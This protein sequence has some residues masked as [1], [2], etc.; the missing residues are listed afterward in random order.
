MFPYISSTIIIGIY[1]FLNW[2][3]PDRLKVFSWLMRLL[4]AVLLGLAVASVDFFI[5]LVF[6]EYDN[7]SKYWEWQFPQYALD[8]MALTLALYTATRVSSLNTRDTGLLILAAVFA[9]WL[10]S[11][12]LFPSLMELF[13]YGSFNFNAFTEEFT[14]LERLTNYYFLRGVVI[15]SA[16]SV[17]FILVLLGRSQA[18]SSKTLSRPGQEITVRF[19]SSSNEPAR[20]LMGMAAAGRLPMI[21][22]LRQEQEHPCQASP[23]ELDVDREKLIE[24]ADKRDEDANSNRFWYFGSAVLALISIGAEAPG[25]V[26]ISILVAGV[27]VFRQGRRDRATLV[28]AYQPK[29]FEPPNPPDGDDSIQNLITYAGYDPFSQFGV[30]FGS[31]VLMVD[32][33]RAK[34]DELVEKALVDP[35]IGEIERT[36]AETMTQ[37]GQ[38]V[39]APR[40]LYFVQGANIPEDIKCE[41]AVRPPRNLHGD[42]FYENKFAKHAADPDSPVRRYLWI[43]KSIWGREISISYFVRLFRHGSD[44]N[45]EING[46][47]MPPVAA[48]YRWVDQFAPQ[49]FWGV[50]FDLFVSLIVGAW[51]LVWTPLYVVG[52]AQDAI[53]EGFGSKDR[54]RRNLARSVERTANYDFGAPVS[55]RKQV[56]DFGP[57]QYFQKMDRRAAEAAFAGRVTRCFIDYLDTCNIDTSELR[58]QRTTL[59]NQGIV[60]QGGDVKSENLAVGAGAKVKALGARARNSMGGGS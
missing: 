31:W 14:N 48:Q 44:L 41:G 4:G 43:R 5:G 38:I 3:R 56:A 39:G 40:P 47:I 15:Y 8:C 19:K 2:R 16:S 30:L 34:Q 11:S 55:I 26:L 46:V 33:K 53:A 29:Q 58:E 13:G 49:G 28:P 17:A 32:T 6:G 60:V 35:D 54:A 20:L 45:L 25:G 59:L 27:V 7:L 22:K 36:I 57:V 10:A 9:A 51:M 37:A 23:F 42:S 52:K 21:S 18:T 1:G 24:L 50:V 12:G